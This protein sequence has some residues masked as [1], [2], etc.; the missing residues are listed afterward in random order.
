M[1]EDPDL[2]IRNPAEVVPRTLNV[3]APEISPAVSPDPITEAMSVLFAFT[4]LWS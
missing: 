4:K 1:M 3:Y 2:T